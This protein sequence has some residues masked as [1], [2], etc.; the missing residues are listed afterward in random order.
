MVVSG[1]RHI[2]TEFNPGEGAPGTHWIG[3]WV[4]L[5]SWSEQR[6]EEKSLV[7]DRTLAVQSLIK[8]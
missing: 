3:G 6:I 5:K 2:S 8:S 1:Q 7:G 4:G